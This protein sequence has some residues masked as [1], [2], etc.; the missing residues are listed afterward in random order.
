MTRRDDQPTNA[1]AGPTPPVDYAPLRSRRDWLL[2]GGGGFG[3]LALSY[4]LGTHGGAA[5]G[6]AARIGRPHHPPRADHVI[7]L[8]MEGGPSHIDLFDPKPTLNKLA[9]QP[10]PKSFKPV[11]LAM[12]ET[13]APLMAS[14]RTWGRYG[15]SGLWMSNWVP[16]LRPYADDIAVVR[17]CWGDGINHAGGVCQM[18]TGATLGGRPSLGA[19]INYGLGTENDNLPAFVEVQDTDTQVVNGP[20]NWGSGFMPAGWQGTRL[21][22]GAEPIANLKTPKS[23]GD[24]RQR[25]K[26]DYLARL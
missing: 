17:S 1:A 7:F 6:S 25:A 2:R 23:V 15:E 4:L 9:G 20:R 8:F 26:L 22:H 24:A 13:N 16:H 12:G 21:S 10:L 19:W 3:S 18:N 11:V 5:P 14:P